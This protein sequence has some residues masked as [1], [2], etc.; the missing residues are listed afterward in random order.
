MPPTMLHPLPPKPTTVPHIPYESRAQA[1]AN[2]THTTEPS[3]SLDCTATKA[4]LG[5]PFK[6][7]PSYLDSDD[8]IVQLRAR[9]RLYK[10]DR[11]WQ[12]VS[13]KLPGRIKP[14]KRLAEIVVDWSSFSIGVAR[15]Y[16]KKPNAEASD[17]SLLAISPCR[18]IDHFE[19]GV[20]NVLTRSIATVD[21]DTL[22]H[23]ESKSYMVLEAQ[24]Q[25]SATL[26][27][28]A[29]LTGEICALQ[30]ERAVGRYELRKR[31]KRLHGRPAPPTTLILVAGGPSA[32][33]AEAVRRGLRGGMNLM[34]Y[35]W[36]DSPPEWLEVFK[37]LWP[38]QVQVKYCDVRAQDF[39]A[40]FEDT[41]STTPHPAL[42]ERHTRH[43]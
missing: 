34:L 30:I 3:I 23:F 16:L 17:F 26:V 35:T 19:R 37:N 12:A 2:G 36:I 5:T 21:K 22:D 1:Q 14:S 15:W 33:Y 10:T 27:S 31:G 38:Q 20:Q 32:Q 41:S 11:R 40:T 13:G 29:L 42:L 8:R 25:L 9:N 4:L 24:A 39:F 6:F 43:P 18:V 28:L 7:T